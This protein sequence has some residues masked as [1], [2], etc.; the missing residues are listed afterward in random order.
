MI[1]FRRT[2]IATMTLIGLVGTAAADAPGEGTGYGHHMWHDGW[3]GV[4]FGPFMTVVFLLVVALIVFFAIRQFG[5]GS[6]LR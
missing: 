5:S 2:A 1:S 3:G 6:T 4:T